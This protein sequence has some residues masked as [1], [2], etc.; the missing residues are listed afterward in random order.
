MLHFRA[1]SAVNMV[2]LALFFFEYDWLG[3]SFDIVV[4]WHDRTSWTHR[5]RA[6]S[7]CMC[8]SIPSRKLIQ[9]FS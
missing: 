1:I 8:T 5:W 7:R 3:I 9:D 6:A 2:I 4:D